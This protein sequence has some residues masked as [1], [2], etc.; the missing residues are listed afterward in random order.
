[1]DNTTIPSDIL[2]D[3]KEA[4]RYA[5]S[6]T[7]DPEVMRRACERMDRLR[8]QTRTRRGV[9]DVAVSLIREAREEDE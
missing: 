7:G 9:L 2:A 1:M 6:G 3:L 5:A 8:E 4:A